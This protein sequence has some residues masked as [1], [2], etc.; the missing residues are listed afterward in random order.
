MSPITLPLASNRSWAQKVR[1][2]LAA[3]PLVLKGCGASS[4]IIARFCDGTTPVSV[5]RGIASGLG[6]LEQADPGRF[7]AFFIN[8]R[9]QVKGNAAKARPR[10]SAHRTLAPARS[11]FRLLSPGFVFST[12]LRA[13]V[14]APESTCPNPDPSP[15]SYPSP[16]DRASSFSIA[17]V[18]SGSPVPIPPPRLSS[19]RF[20]FP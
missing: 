14:A 18:R 13:A 16:T 15:S 3:P 4:S 20:P 2:G 11:S 19:S 12:A 6:L 8:Y 7:R 1:T 5:A 17:A 9:Q 10:K